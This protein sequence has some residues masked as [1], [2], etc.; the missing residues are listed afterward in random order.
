MKNMSKQ[1]TQVDDTYV[2][3]CPHCDGVVVVNI[4]EVN[5]QIFRHAVLKQNGEQINPHAPQQECDYL[6]VNDLVWGCGKPFRVTYPT[7]DKCDYI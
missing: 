6:F 3:E 5:C 2:F 1:V 7:V 4:H